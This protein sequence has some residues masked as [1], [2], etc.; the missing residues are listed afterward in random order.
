MARRCWRCDLQCA[1]KLDCVGGPSRRKGRVP[2]SISR[3][4]VKEGFEEGQDRCNRNL[5]PCS[6]LVTVAR[7][8]LGG[9]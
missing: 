9:W 7:Q 8:A 2:Y 5:I 4:E 1:R 6:D 3:Q